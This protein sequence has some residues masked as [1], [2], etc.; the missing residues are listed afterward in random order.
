MGTRCGTQ[1]CFGMAVAS[2]HFQSKMFGSKSDSL[3]PA[4]TLCCIGE[5]CRRGKLWPV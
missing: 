5:H 2:P 3:E 1:I 4:G